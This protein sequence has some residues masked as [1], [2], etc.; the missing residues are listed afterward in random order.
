M[1]FV[2]ND[3][4]NHSAQACIAMLCGTSLLK[5]LSEVGPGQLEFI[6]TIHLLEKR[7]IRIERYLQPSMETDYERHRIQLDGIA[8]LPIMETHLVRLIPEDRSQGHLLLVSESQILDPSS[9]H[10]YST[11]E[12]T[13][14]AQQVPT[15]LL[16][17]IYAFQVV[18]N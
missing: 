4:Y 3:Q 7:G 5:V 16:Y 10:P 9:D 18:R 11:C 1:E 6:A 8:R 17:D 15:E 2:R 14:W 13:Q 12:I